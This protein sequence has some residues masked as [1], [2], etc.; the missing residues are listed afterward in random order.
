MTTEITFYGTSD[1][2]VEVG[3]VDNLDEINTNYDEPELFDVKYQDPA[4]AVDGLRV[5]VAY[6]KDGLWGV[7]VEP[8]EDGFPIPEWDIRIKRPHYSKDYSTMLAIN[9][10]EGT[11]VERITD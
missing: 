10:P 11:T 8:L 3:G 7:R 6:S 5:E 9:A 4:G 2:L 1:D